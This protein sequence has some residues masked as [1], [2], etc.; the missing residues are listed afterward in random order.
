MWPRTAE[1]AEGKSAKVQG[2]LAEGILW[3]RRRA[4][5]ALGVY[6]GIKATMG[7]VIVGNRNGV[8]GSEED[9]EST[10]GTK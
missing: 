1:E 4:G 3:E 8:Y 10:K 2:S 9:S 6:L 7:E 5:G